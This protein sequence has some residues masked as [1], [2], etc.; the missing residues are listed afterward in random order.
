MESGF[1][2]GGGD[3]E[4]TFEG[5]GFLGLLVNGVKTWR[6]DCRISLAGVYDGLTGS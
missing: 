3:E 6:S 5:N 2:M 4:G 1:G